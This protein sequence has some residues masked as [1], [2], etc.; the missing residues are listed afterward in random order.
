MSPI[1]YHLKLPPQW[2]IHPVFHIDLLTPYHKTIT[3]GDNY[4][5]PPPELV[6]K[7]EEFEVWAI[8]D[9]RRFGWRHQLQYLIKWK[10]YPE[11][12]NQWE[13]ADNVHSD[14]LVCCFQRQHPTKETHLKRGLSTKSSSSPLMSSP[15]SFTVELDITLVPVLN[16]ITE[17]RCNFP[18]PEP[19][20][21][22]PDSTQTM[23]VD[24]DPGTQV[25]GSQDD[26]GSIG[27]DSQTASAYLAEAGGEEA[28]SAS[29][30]NVS[31][32]GSG[33]PS[34]NCHSNIGSH[35]NSKCSGEGGAYCHCHDRCGNHFNNSCAFRDLY[36]R[37]ATHA[38]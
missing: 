13:N 33:A 22:S 16:A 32:G 9:S 17:A 14:D 29:S 5:C 37:C 28:T 23:W 35:V 19:A 3:H 20:W 26:K 4:L 12:E 21:L 18:T 6:D 1:S 38:K 10:G 15:D 2:R 8:L 27:V 34:S 24:L 7:E 25:E 36:L 31:R 30:N 11:S